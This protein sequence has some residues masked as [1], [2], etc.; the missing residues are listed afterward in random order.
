MWTWP[1]RA[2]FGLVFQ[3]LLPFILFYL[4]NWDRAKDET[5]GYLCVAVRPGEDA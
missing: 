1:L 4:D 5:L 3:L 2:L